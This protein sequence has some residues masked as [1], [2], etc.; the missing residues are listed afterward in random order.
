M[1]RLNANDG[2]GQYDS[3]GGAGAMGNHRAVSALGITTTLRLDL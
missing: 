2:G 3:S 1:Y